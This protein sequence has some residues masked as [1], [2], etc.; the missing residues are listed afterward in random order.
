MAFAEVGV[1]AQ[2]E[3]VARRAGVGVGTVYRHFETKE[4]LVDA[5]LVVRF[6]QALEVSRAALEI[7]DPW[8]AV[9]FAMRGQ[10][11]LQAQ[12]RCFSDVIGA[13]LPS[14]EPVQP[15]MAEL[16][17]VWRELIARAQGAGEMRRDVTVEDVPALMC[18]LAT[19]ASRAP[20][21]EVWERYL[22]IMLDG[23]RVAATPLPPLP[24]G[25]PFP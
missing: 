10:A 17:K 25:L 2:M 22:G 6:G 7:A 9:A 23:L 11:L 4:A 19:V 15:V 24:P 14:S 1:E 16:R 20:A 3:D 18:A 12:D 21:T 8:E 5:L 13:Q